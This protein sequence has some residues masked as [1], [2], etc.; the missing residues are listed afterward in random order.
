MQ[1]NEK[2]IPSLDLFAA[3]HFKPKTATPLTKLISPYC[4]SL[5]PI[6]LSNTILMSS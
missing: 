6:K 5:K 3:S 2:I 1:E 4:G